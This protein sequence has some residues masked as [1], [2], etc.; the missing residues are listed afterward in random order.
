[1]TAASLQAE[2]ERKLHACLVERGLRTAPQSY[3][4]DHAARLEVQRRWLERRYPLAE[5]PPDGRASAGEHFRK[6]AT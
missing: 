5:R 2:A 3:P 1:M 4:S 6:A